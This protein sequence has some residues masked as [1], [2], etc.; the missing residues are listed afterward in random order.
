MRMIKAINYTI[1]KAMEMSMTM[2][3]S[4]RDWQDWVSLKRALHA[5]WNKK[6]K[7]YWLLAQFHF[8]KS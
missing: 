1:Y 8:F 2:K 5:W 6:C 7:Q 4:F 3:L